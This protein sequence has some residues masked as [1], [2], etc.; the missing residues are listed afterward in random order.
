[1]NEHANSIRKV[2]SLSIE[3]ISC[4]FMIFEGPS[5]DMIG[6][7]EASVIKG[8]G[9]EPANGP[10]W[11]FRFPMMFKLTDMEDSNERLQSIAG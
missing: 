5:S 4:R 9:F 10:Q 7:L 3:D 6:T 2:D 8:T 11:R 1:M